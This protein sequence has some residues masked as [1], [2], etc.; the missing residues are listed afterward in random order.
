MK[1]RVYVET[2]VVSYLTGRLSRDV[3]VLGNQV[4]T[5][6]W[7]RDASQQFELVASPLVIDEA[8]FGDPNA[9]RDRLAV[10]ESLAIILATHG[11][12]T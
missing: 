7:W 10:L 5:R 6:D 9:S 11:D 1:P 2:S 8:S 4:A 12:T 3:M